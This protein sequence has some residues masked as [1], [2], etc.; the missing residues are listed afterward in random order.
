MR[1][2]VGGD[3]HAF[4]ELAHRHAA[5]V[6]RLAQSIV[7]D[8]SADDVLQETLTAVFRRSETFRGPSVRGW[9][10]AIARNTARRWGRT[11]GRLEPTDPA[12]FELGCAAGWGDPRLVDVSTRADSDFAVTEALGRLDPDAR[13]VLLL[14]DVLGLSGEE[15]SSVLKISLPALKSRLH[16]ARLELVAA[17]RGLP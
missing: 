8:T 13:E 16:R 11:Q 17:L 15:A 14:R 10:F 2:V 3:A 1:L 4:G 7:G 9:I 5:A 12:W 6:R